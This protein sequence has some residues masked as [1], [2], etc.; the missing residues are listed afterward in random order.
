MFW[1]QIKQTQY[2]TDGTQLYANL[3]N[4]NTKVRYE[5]VSIILA[6]D[7]EPKS[8]LTVAF[9]PGEDLDQTKRMAARVH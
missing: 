8:D 4:N 2:Y 6:W 7:N 1:S 3:Y 5:G 9:V